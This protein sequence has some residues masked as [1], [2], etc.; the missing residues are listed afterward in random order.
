MKNIMNQITLFPSQVQH[1]Q[2]LSKRLVELRLAFDLSEMGSGKTY[3]A[4][5]TAKA[6][7]DAGQCTKI[8]F[9]VPNEPAKM[10]TRLARNIEVPFSL[11]NYTKLVNFAAE[12]TNSKT[13]IICDEV[14]EV[15][16]NNKTT[17]KID[18]FMI[19]AKKSNAM[20]LLLSATPF[21]DYSKAYMLFAHVGLIQGS[22]IPLAKDLKTY[23]FPGL[24]KKYLDEYPEFSK[25]LNPLL[26]YG[27]T[28]EQM[29]KSIHD[30]I[31]SVYSSRMN[32]ILPTDLVMHQFNMVFNHDDIP[33]YESVLESFSSANA[34]SMNKYVENLE[35]LKLP[36]MAQ[37]GLEILK[38]R[39]TNKIILCVSNNDMVNF[40]TMFYTRNNYASIYINS[41]LTQL[42]RQVAQNQFNAYSLTYRVMILTY[43]VASTGISLH[44]NAPSSIYPLGFPRVM[45][46]FIPINPLTR[47]QLFG[48]HIRTGI[49]SKLVSTLVLSTDAIIDGKTEREIFYNKSSMNT[50]LI[51][52]SV[53][54]TTEPSLFPVVVKN[55]PENSCQV[56][57]KIIDDLDVYT[58]DE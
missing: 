9:L 16:A 29:F 34:V 11:H 2:E 25:N 17:A 44:D 10:W 24:I 52:Q 1:H 12:N 13:L 57:K 30:V 58:V 4:I 20:I 37:L 48:R 27:K 55:I 56:M 50:V 14:Q 33:G 19:K 31:I 35:L 43:S 32:C 7:F 36:K 23:D 5:Y 18:D 21:T 6:L 38:S 15:A 46:S 51:N 26:S 47:T 3:V 45:L 42:G 22:P 28:K 40:L 54:S 8:I 41:G 53:V 39:E 49:T